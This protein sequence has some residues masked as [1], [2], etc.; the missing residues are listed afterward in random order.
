MWPLALLITASFAQRVTLP[1]G[2]TLQGG[3][4]S[5]YGYT[6]NAMYFTS[7]PY[8][9]P[10]TGDL[11]F[12]APQPYDGAYGG[13]HTTLTP[14]CRVFDHSSFIEAIPDKMCLSHIAQ[15][16]RSLT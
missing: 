14:N 4:C 15:S 8:A 12:A 16:S 6:N 3:Q 9:Q 13:S 2:D 5:E 7:V 1:N 11:R 10:P